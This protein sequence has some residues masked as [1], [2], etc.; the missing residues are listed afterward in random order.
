MGFYYTGKYTSGLL[1]RYDV[2][3]AIQNCIQRVEQNK[4]DAALSRWFGDNSQNFK[5]EVRKKLNILRSRIN[6]MQI[7]VGFEDMKTRNKFTNAA[8]YT[9]A[10]TSLDPTSNPNV[11]NRHV[12]LDLNF[13]KLPN[14][15]PLSG[16]QIDASGYNQ[17]Q[18]ETFVHELSHLILATEDVTYLQG[19]NTY[20]AYGAQRALLIATHL[21]DEAKKNA[22]NWGIFVEAC[23]YYE[24]S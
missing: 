14:Y 7:N 22:E 24:T 23:G 16:G 8:A 15:L 12:F 18:F 11:G 6:L 17:S 9:G 21:P 20:T 1:S 5:N 13:K 2:Y 4:A 19:G 3:Q 10:V